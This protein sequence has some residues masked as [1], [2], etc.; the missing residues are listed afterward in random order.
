ML[1]FRA[2][3]DSQ[4]ASFMLMCSFSLI[5]LLPATQANTSQHECTHGLLEQ[6]GYPGEG[7]LQCANSMARCVLS[8]TRAA[9]HH[10]VS[11]QLQ[12]KRLVS[13]RVPEHHV[14]G[15]GHLWQR[16]ARGNGAPWKAWLR[17]I[18]EV[19]PVPNA[20]NLHHFL[21]EIDQCGAAIV[22]WELAPVHHLCPSRLQPA[23]HRD[24]CSSLQVALS[25]R[26]LQVRS[27]Q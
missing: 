8:E 14:S 9:L 6:T 27:Q 7:M 17:T 11:Q 10:A 12:L 15:A 2:V 20:T 16:E 4:R 25:G 5:A 23:F 22:L 1:T 3:S 26:E 18:M 24:E 19:G 21:H 13:F